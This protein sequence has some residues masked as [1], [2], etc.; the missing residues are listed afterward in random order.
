M[1]LVG[2]IVGITYLEANSVG[3]Y[4][5]G[6]A[7]SALLTLLLLRGVPIDKIQVGDRITIDFQIEDDSE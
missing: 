7:V 1:T 5:F 6:L 2:V 3:L 4:A